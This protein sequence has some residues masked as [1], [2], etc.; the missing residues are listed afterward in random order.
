MTTRAKMVKEG[1][2]ANS[3]LVFAIMA[4][5][6][7]MGIAQKDIQTARFSIQPVYTPQEPRTEPKLSG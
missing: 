6:K 3:N 7:E 4:A 5:L 2:A 1:V